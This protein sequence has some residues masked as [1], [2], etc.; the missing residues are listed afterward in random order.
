M[1]GRTGSVL[2]QSGFDTNERRIF[3]SIQNKS[4]ANDMD[5]K[6]V[7]YA[8]SKGDKNQSDNKTPEE[9]THNLLGP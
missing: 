6:G 1:G 2:D 9:T 3:A 7:K 5:L 4:E 8:A